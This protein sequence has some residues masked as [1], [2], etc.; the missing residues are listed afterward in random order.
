MMKAHFLKVFVLLFI[1]YFQPAIGQEQHKKLHHNLAICAI[2]RNDA[3]YLKEW[4]E[5]HRLV[6]VEHFFLY[7]HM[8]EDNYKEVLQPYVEEGIV[9]IVEWPYPISSTLPW[10]RIQT[11][12]YNNAILKNKKTVKWAAFIDTDEFLFPVEKDNLLDFL[13]DFETFGGVCANWQMFGTSNI[14][15]IPKGIL[16]I[17]SLLYK[18]D[19]DFSANIHVKSIVRPKCVLEF[20]NPHY[21]IYK[22]G[23][24]QVN[25]DSQPFTGPFSP[26]VAIDK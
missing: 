6:G 1:S 13:N 21:A 9:D 24:F 19:T 4:I 22:K 16:L 5:F 8:S 23:F 18:A 15:K 3:P 10:W 12:A 26:N 17:E 11:G 7:N 20:I 25:S 14:A 2:F